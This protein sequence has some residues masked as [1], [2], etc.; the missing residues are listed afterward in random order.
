VGARKFR[1]SE[2]LL[3]RA[4]LPLSTDGMRLRKR[5]LPD[6]GR[7]LRSSVRLH[8]EEPSQDCTMK[9][10]LP[11]SRDLPA[12]ELG[13]AHKAYRLGTDEMGMCEEVFQERRLKW[14]VPVPAGSSDSDKAIR[15]RLKDADRIY[16][17]GIS[18]YV[19]E[20]RHG[21]AHASKA[22]RLGD[23]LH[24]WFEPRNDYS[25]VEE[26]DVTVKVVLTKEQP[27]GSMPGRKGGV[28]GIVWD[29]P[30]VTYVLDQVEESIS[31]NCMQERE[32]LW[33]APVPDE[34][35]RD[36][37]AMGNKYG[38]GSTFQLNEKIYYVFE[39]EEG[40]HDAKR[41]AKIGNVL[42]VWYDDT[43]DYE[44]LGEP[45]EPT[46]AKRSMPV[47]LE[48]GGVTM[49]TDCCS[50]LVRGGGKRRLLV[51]HEKSYCQETINLES[52]LAPGMSR[53][54][55]SDL[56]YE[57][58]LRRYPGMSIVAEW[59]GEP[60]HPRTDMLQQY[61][62]PSDAWVTHGHEES[63]W[64]I[65]FSGGFKLELVG[66]TGR[67]KDAGVRDS[68]SAIYMLSNTIIPGYLRVFALEFGAEKRGEK[69]LVLGE[70]TLLTV[71]ADA[72]GS[73]I[74]T[75][76]MNPHTRY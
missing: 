49:L 63:S 20:D 32:L 29:Q 15:N 21:F 11:L 30:Y 42:H 35:K 8:L 68:G 59:E 46:A 51:L 66:I 53:T 45:G 4:G 13:H 76:E 75:A 33:L 27:P 48:E 71:A 70:R 2:T 3:G 39:G 65:G 50:L 54:I 10:Q 23:V 19:F 14:I 17:R 34:A 52:E 28:K 12:I 6:I 62:H 56:G 55:I 72:V 74:V 37:V 64:T 7:V 9:Q 58:V 1:L 16:L 36:P 67:S 41:V 43:T 40:D 5:E 38:W 60:C 25:V 24:I 22:A 73:W 44:L 69:H 18:Y 31:S 61:A 57:I 47:E 26:G